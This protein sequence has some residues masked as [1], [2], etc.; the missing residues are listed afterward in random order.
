[1]ICNLGMDEE[2]ISEIS[3]PPGLSS[4]K[5]FE[6]HSF[7]D[8]VLCRTVKGFDP[9]EILGKKGLRNKDHAT[10]LLLGTFEKSFKEILS[11]QDEQR[12]PGFCIGTAFGS[13]QSIGDFLS[14]SIVNGVNSVNPQAFANTVINSPTGNANIR[15]MVRNLSTTISTGFN[16]GLDSIIY[17]KDYISR[18]YLSR[19]IAGGLEEISYYWLLGLMRSGMISEEGEAKPLCVTSDGIIPGEGCALFLIENE[20]EAFGNGSQPRAEIAGEASGFDPL[21]LSGRSD[22]STGAGIIEKALFNAKISAEAIDFVASGGSGHYFTDK[23]ECAAIQTVF[24]NNVPV[25]AYKHA[26]GECYG[27]SGALITA[28]ALRDMKNGTISGTGL[29]YE[30]I[31]GI[32]LVSESIKAAPEYVLVTSFS[33]EGNCS[34]IVLRNI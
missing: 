6:F 14:D 31:N 34:A 26:I 20:D 3:S 29:S 27:A 12:R 7:D 9:V 23:V 2:N 33:C 13:L 28:L 21:L 24:K 17:A 15:Y 11:D 22:G 19:I 32:N 18:N 1:M 16:A 25:T 10:K 5:D 30:T 4:V 8:P